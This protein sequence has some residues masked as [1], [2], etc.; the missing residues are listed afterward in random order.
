MVF[1]LFQHCCLPQFTYRH[2]QFL[3]NYHL[4]IL[5]CL[6]ELPCAF[7]VISQYLVLFSVAHKFDTPSHIEFLCHLLSV[8]G[9]WW[10]EKGEEKYLLSP[11]LS[12]SSMQSFFW[13]SGGPV[14]VGIP[15][16]K[17]EFS[18][19]PSHGGMIKATWCHYP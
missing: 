11:R 14:S 5:T 9:V 18:P 12:D 8:N 10:S 19:T 2:F 15:C 13:L 7:I 6:I 16:W 3:R 17:R 1:H 4:Q